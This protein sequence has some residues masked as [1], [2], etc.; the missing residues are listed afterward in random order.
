MTSRARLRLDRSKILR[1]R[2]RFS[3]LF[4]QG[5]AVRTRR[6][7]FKFV[8]AR[9]SPVDDSAS[10]AELLCG[11]IV[12]R[13]AGIAVVRNRI[14][15]R[16]RES[17]RLRRNWL[18]DELPGGMAMHM[19]VLWLPKGSPSHAELASIDEEMHQGLRRLARALKEDRR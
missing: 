8:V 6:L 1:G 13:S 3:C 16:M 18:V 14:R 11:F 9:Q 7:L 2:A 17:F 5:R 19:A 4:E 12:R 15:R 10:P